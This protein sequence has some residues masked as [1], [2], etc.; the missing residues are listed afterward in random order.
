MA[1][2]Q[3]ELWQRR[4]K[5]M[6][7]AIEEGA[8]ANQKVQMDKALK[9]ARDLDTASPPVIDRT[10]ERVERIARIELERPNPKPDPV[11]DFAERQEAFTALFDEELVGELETHLRERFDAQLYAQA[12]ETTDPRTVDDM[13]EEAMTSLLEAIVAVDS[14]DS[15]AKRDL[16]APRGTALSPSARDIG[17][18]TAPLLAA[19]G[20]GMAMLTPQLGP[21]DVRCVAVDSSQPLST[22]LSHKANALAGAFSKCVIMR[23][24]E[25]CLVAGRN[26]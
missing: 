14:L 24:S 7:D 23:L 17:E 10:P 19:L 15:L 9:V 6:W 18:Q 11:R 3:N 2:A 4:E 26:V 5:E 22:D 12:D 16:S 20:I 21:V 13:T 8:L 25:A 1:V